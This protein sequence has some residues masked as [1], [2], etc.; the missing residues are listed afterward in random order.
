MSKA[1]NIERLHCTRIILQM[2]F[3]CHGIKFKLTNSILFYSELGSFPLNIEHN[4]RSIKYWL[5]LHNR[6]RRKFYFMYYNI[7]TTGRHRK[8]QRFKKY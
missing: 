5:H 7:Q 1:E 6:K 4:T 8:Q 3:N 2:D